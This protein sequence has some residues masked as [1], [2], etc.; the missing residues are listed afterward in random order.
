MVFIINNLFHFFEKGAHSFVDSNSSVISMSLLIMSK[1]LIY[2]LIIQ[3]LMDEMLCEM[4][5]ITEEEWQYIDSRIH[6]Y[7]K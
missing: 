1:H 4:L 7:E 5:D 6:N 3:V 2:V